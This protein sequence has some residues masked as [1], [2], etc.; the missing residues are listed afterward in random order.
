MNPP[1]PPR[2]VK[3][4]KVTLMVVDHDGIGPSDIKCELE[5]TRYS[6]HCMS[7]R[8]MEV[9]S[10]EVQW[11]DNHL[12]NYQTTEAQEFWRLFDKGV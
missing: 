7:P 1:D 5:H 11:T 9:E 3:V 10:R 8:V 2:P 4:Y 12:L 6:N